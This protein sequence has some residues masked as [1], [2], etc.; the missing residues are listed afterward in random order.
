[1]HMVTFVV[2]LA[3]LE[4]LSPHDLSGGLS[5]AEIIDVIR[6]QFDYLPGDVHVDVS[7]GVAT[8]QF[9]GASAQEQ[10]E[11]RR[12]FGKAAKRGKSGEFQ[13]AK[14]IYERVLELDPAMA[15]ARREMAM[16]LFE[17]GDMS[18]AKDQ[19][20][21]AL[22]L[23]PDDAWSYV[24]L[25][26]IY[27]KHDRDLTTAARF[28]TRALELKPGDP[29]ALNSLAAVS[30]ELGDTAK[31]LRCF[32]EAITTH[33]EFANAWVGKAMLLNAQDQPAQVVEVLD[34]MFSRA[35]VMDARTQPIFAEGRE[36][37]L[38]ARRE[39]A[40]AQLSDVFKTLETYK[41][42]VAT[43]SGYPV[44]VRIE[45]MP[46]QLS[47]VAQMAWKHGRNHHFVQ[48]SEKYPPPDRQ[49]VEAH[50]VTH[51]RLE[52]LARR[53]SR[54]RWFATT[55]ASRE[56]A[57]RSLASD[58]KKLER[59]GYSGD[60]ITRLV[61][62]LVGGL[63]ACLFNA[64]LDMWIETLLHRDLPALRHAQFVSLHRLAGEAFA[65]TTRSEIRQ[66]TP[67]KI[68]RAF[69]SLNGASAL[70]LDDFTHGATAFWPHYQRLDG[71]N[72]SPRLFALW[73]ERRDALLDL[74]GWYEWRPDPGTHEVTEA[75]AREGTTN[76]EL[77]QQ[78]HP[79][80]VL[81][82]LDA[83]RRYAALN[84]EQ[85]REIAFEIGM[86]GQRG[87]DYA[88]PAPKY[89]LRTLPGETFTGLQLMCL[90]HAGFKRLAPE[91]DTGMDLDEPFLTALELFN[92]KEEQE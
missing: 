62:D 68:L 24:V 72:L 91:Q 92:A 89:T 7:D 85:V 28:F 59:Q 15:D 90:M 79:A 70:F 52:A 8:I 33:P 42:D 74:R 41:A 49:H 53:R 76:P 81:H 56:L 61:L 48:I 73:Q 30:T 32:D 55:P 51:I 36:L 38:S 44:K 87:L 12:L 25:G 11:A 14:G 20:I 43:L 63:S 47:G 2:R 16:T 45:A 26:N 21:D 9:E 40:E 58:V 39:L 78:K 88:D 67:P 22:R 5:A 57:I 66:S 37:Y 80:A 60:S 86:L 17:L 35:A 13:K 6:R 75:P 50:E 34:S 77:L 69:T 54:N 71:A 82:L 3:D 31:A 84:V 46:G 65:A 1:M 19:L 27:V 10:A 29:Y 18:A 83:L 4:F 64:P 23:E